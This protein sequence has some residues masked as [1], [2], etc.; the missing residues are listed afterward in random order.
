MVTV[1]QT[2]PLQNYD[3]SLFELVGISDRIDL[4]NVYG[5]GLHSLQQLEISNLTN[6]PVVVKLQSTLKDQLNFQLYNEN[7]ENIL[8]K[9]RL[10]TNT[11]EWSQHTQNEHCEFNQLFNYVN[12]IDTIELKP[13][14]S[15]PFILAFLP[16]QETDDTIYD[17]DDGADLC[18]ED[19]NNSDHGLSNMFSNVAGKI[20]LTGFYKNNPLMISKRVYKFKADICEP[21]LTADDVETGLVFE[22]VLVGETYMK[23]IVIRNQSAIELFWKLNVADLSSTDRGDWLQFIDASN[24][25]LIDN[26]MV[27]GP[28]SQFILRAVFTPKEAGKFDYDL[29][30]ENTND[31]RNIIQTRIHATSRTFFLHKETLIVSSGNILDFGDCIAGSWN[32][33]Q[34]SLLNKGDSP[35]EIHFRAD[36]AELGFDIKQK[37]E[38]EFT[39]SST[40]Q[41]PPGHSGQKTPESDQSS[42]ESPRP[43]SPSSH[44]TNSTTT[45][46]EHTSSSDSYTSTGFSIFIC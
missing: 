25:Q 14:Q 9:R 44:R 2:Q 39:R 26:V 28:F 38:E 34:I 24:F 13:E 6:E 10:A 29:Q 1:I 18:S 32:K 5:N 36:G 20:T 43:S 17:G 15:L 41:I 7:M 33:Q 19:S 11:V 8:N 46:E 22:D 37:P 4:N 45:F 27:I 42:S 35:I 21:F 3:S 31:T 23:D 40:P 16:W 30:I 12:Y